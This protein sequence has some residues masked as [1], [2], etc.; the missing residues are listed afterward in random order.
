MNIA[1]FAHF[2]FVNM[3]P[4]IRVIPGIFC[5]ARFRFVE[6]AGAHRINHD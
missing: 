5:V 1:S 3:I 4:G 6:T 2:H